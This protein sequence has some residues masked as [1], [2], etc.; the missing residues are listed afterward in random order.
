MFKE[1]M[2]CAQ[3]QNLENT[4]YLVIKLDIAA[5]NSFIKAYLNEQDRWVD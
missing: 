5:Q 3:V 2:E 1:L 4:Y